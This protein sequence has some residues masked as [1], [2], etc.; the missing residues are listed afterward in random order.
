MLFRCV[1]KLYKDLR[2]QAL[3][4]ANGDVE[5]LGRM[6]ESAMKTTPEQSL[7][8]IRALTET[9]NLVNAA[10]VHHRTRLLRI[11]DKVSSRISALPLREDSVAGSIEEIINNKCSKQGMS[12][13][14]VKDQIYDRLLKQK[15]D[16]VLTAHPTEV[17]RRTLLRK[18][19]TISE[20]LAVLD[21]EDMTPFERAQAL[22]NLKREIA[23]IW[24]SDQIRRQKPSPQQEARGGLAILESVL[25]DAVPSY[26]RKLNLQSIQSLGKPLPLRHTPIKFS[27]WMGGDRDGN[28]NVTPAVTYEVA[29]TQRMQAA[30][31]LM[32]D[33]VTLYK[34]LAICRGFSPKMKRLA[35]AVRKSF[36]KRELY[37]RVLGHVRQRL[38]A[39][40][41]WCEAE[42]DRIGAEFPVSLHISQSSENSW[43]WR[44]FLKVQDL[45]DED[46]DLDEEMDRLAGLP[47]QPF[48]DKRE[49]SEILE[50]IHNSLSSG[51]YA[52]VADGLLIDLIRRV[53]VFGLTLVPLDIR[54]E[55][56][57]HLNAIDAIARYLGIGSYAQWD[58]ATKINWLNN[59]LMSKRP[60]FRVSDMHNLGFDESV[61]TTLRTFETIARLGPGSLGAYVISQSKAA[62]DVLAVMLL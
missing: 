40:L 56:T 52:D 15:V 51:G 42:L 48:F 53:N 44:E 24:G 25:W 22:T 12:E 4:R 18:Y 9:L 38:M 43:D 33:V 28:P 47:N 37:R 5:A 10:E 32:N 23:S 14:L 58:E 13:S 39:T 54:E 7:G 20:L 45:D 62:S 29:I 11:A 17:N 16:L 60:L 34:E 2:D 46:H 26:L 8:V 36:D 31:L 55:S 19:R 30:K 3:K 41:D 21:R 1:I 61:M 35:K 49:L 57:K 59:E 50:V 6:V 27:S